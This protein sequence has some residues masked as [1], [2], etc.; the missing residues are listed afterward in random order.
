M[1]SAHARIVSEIGLGAQAPDAELRSEVGNAVFLSSHW[2]EQPLVLVLLSDLHAQP[3]VDQVLT[4]RDAH[5]TF[6]QAGGDIIAVVRND[7]AEIATLR[8]EYNVTY[9]VLSDPSGVAHKAYGTSPNTPASFV[10]DK[11]GIVRY[12]HYA[13]TILDTPSTWELVDAVCGLTGEAVER[14]EPTKL[15]PAPVSLHDDTAE[16]PAFVMGASVKAAAQVDYA[17][18][19]CENTAYE[20]VK[21]ATSG[22]WISR[23]FNF[24]YRNFVAVVCKACNYAEL[25]RTKGGAA[26]N[27][28]DI[29]I[30]S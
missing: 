18:S 23:I 3:S 13:A 12:A 21:V 22:G 28:A 2:E 1:T 26:A 16:R 8:A 27:I 25:Y 15:M 4:L 29:L 6:D 24:Q 11:R 7:G 20:I 10:I 5:D 30:G 19:K 9:A 14:P 17:C